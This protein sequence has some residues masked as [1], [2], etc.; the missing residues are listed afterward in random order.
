[1]RFLHSKKALVLAV[2]TV[3]VAALA[4]VGIAA[5]TSQTVSADATNESA[6][7][8]AP[9]TTSTRAGTSTG[10]RDRAGSDGVVP[11]HPGELYA[12]DGGSRGHIHRDPVCAGARR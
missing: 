1:M 3:A 11:D 12:Q 6:S 5:V 7:S 4:A 9:R 10:A 8:R 2:A